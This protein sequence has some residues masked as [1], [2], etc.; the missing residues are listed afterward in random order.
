MVDGDTFLKRES[1]VSFNLRVL[2]DVTHAYC[3]IKGLDVWYNFGNNNLENK[4][5][6][7]NLVS[8]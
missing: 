5:F 8:S 7:I 1:T 4:T 2:E 3:H 6:L